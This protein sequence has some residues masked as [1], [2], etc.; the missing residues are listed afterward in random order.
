ML[1]ATKRLLRD[2][3]EIKKNDIPT[4]G[5]TAQPLDNNLF[6]WHANIRGPEKTLYEGG[7]F[8]LII[9]I[10]ESYPHSPPTITIPSPIPHPNVFGN[11]VCLDMLTPDGWSSAY[12]I[13]SVL[14]QLQSFLFE[15]NYDEKITESI[16]RKAVEESN[17][18]KCEGKGCKHGGR[19]A[20]HPSFNVE[21]ANPEAFKILSSEKQLYRKEI[22]CY[23]TKLDLKQTSIGIGMSI[24][25]VPRTG[26]ISQASPCLDLLSLKAFLKEG[27]R[28]GIDKDKKF[29]NWLPLYFGEDKEKVLHLGKRAISMIFTNNTKRFSPKMIVELFPK[30]LLTLNFLMMD[31]KMHCSIRYIRLWTHIHAL[32]LLF[33]EEFKECYDIMETMLD[34][35]LN[36]ESQRNKENTPNLGKKMFKIYLICSKVLYYYTCWYQENI[37]SNRFCKLILMNN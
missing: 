21:E 34:D 13:L 6:I 1:I 25:R 28:N 29:M 10:P 20:C 9:E 11:S 2:L 8:H 33:L 23:H 31:E 37:N 15:K 22:L 18:Y 12:T 35:F 36:K 14:I 5:V 26:A 7:I 32:F 30:I 27:V 24:S 16:I 3:E 19:L 17:Q 4:V